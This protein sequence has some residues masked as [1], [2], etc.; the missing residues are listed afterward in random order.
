MFAQIK[1]TLK[2][3]LMSKGRE[4]TVWLNLAN[5]V[6]GGIAFIVARFVK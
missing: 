6:K 2:A 5:P 1:H 4:K 3:E